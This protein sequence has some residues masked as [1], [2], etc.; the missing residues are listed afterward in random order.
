[1]IYVNPPEIGF[2]FLFLLIIFLFL[3]I[4][5]SIKIKE[6]LYNIVIDWKLKRNQ[7]EGI[8]VNQNQDEYN[9]NKEDWYDLKAKK[10]KRYMKKRFI[11]DCEMKY[12]YAIKKAIPEELILR[13]QICLASI[14]NKSGNHVFANELFKIIDFGVFDKNSNILLLIEINDSSHEQYYRVQRDNK[15]K[16]ICAEANIPLI[17]FW[18][19]FG[20]DEQYI[21]KRI[22]ECLED[23]H[24][25]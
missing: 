15:V 6:E 13:P 2:I 12:G 17:T 5:Q 21:Q 23:L 22:N 10:Q 25:I 24:M 11:T 4:K 3:A 18:T 16:N 19:K 20:I 7:K 9:A 8:R 14:L 1:M